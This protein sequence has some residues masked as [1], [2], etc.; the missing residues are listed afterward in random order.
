MKK[1]VLFVLFLS[2][3][4]CEYIEKEHLKTI[5][6]RGILVDKFIDESNHCSQ[7][8]KVRRNDVVFFLLASNYPNSW[9]FANNGDSIIKEKGELYL[10]IK[11]K[12]GDSTMFPYYE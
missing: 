12:D 8:F 5:S 2:L 9:E 3:F 11:N 4:S 6:F 1:I 7:T 10:T